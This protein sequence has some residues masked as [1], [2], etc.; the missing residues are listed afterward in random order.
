MIS[1]NKITAHNAGIAH[2]SEAP[3]Q[4]TG[5]GGSYQFLILNPTDRRRGLAADG[6]TAFLPVD[7]TPG[8]KISSDPLTQEDRRHEGGFVP[9][10]T[11]EEVRKIDRD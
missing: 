4:S 5:A 11:G 8:A 3:H 6:K 9:R 1:P 2:M 7:N 10:S